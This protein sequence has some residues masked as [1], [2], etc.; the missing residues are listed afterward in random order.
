MG[1][2]LPGRAGQDWGVA[3]PSSRDVAVAPGFYLRPYALGPLS[4]E[5]GRERAAG[6]W[7]YFVRGPSP[8][9]AAPDPAAGEILGGVGPG[10]GVRGVW[11]QP[12]F[13]NACAAAPGRTLWV[14]A[15]KGRRPRPF[16]L[17][18]DRPTKLIIHWC[19]LFSVHMNTF[20]VGLRQFFES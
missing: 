19:Y 20:W 10:D 15:E 9:Q 7:R 4:G 12:W 8:D 3:W 14:L 5:V 2:F 16:A 18:M 1:F 13:K 11:G 6:R 17:G